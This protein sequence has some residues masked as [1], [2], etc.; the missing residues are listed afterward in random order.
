MSLFLLCKPSAGFCHLCLSLCGSELEPPQRLWQGLEVLEVEKTPPRLFTQ[1]N[2]SSTQL[3][4]GGFSH[5][6]VWS[7][8][9][10]PWTLFLKGFS[11]AKGQGT[12]K[13]QDDEKAQQQR[14]L[15]FRPPL[16][17]SIWRPP[18]A[19]D[20]NPEAHTNSPSFAIWEV[21]VLTRM[22][23]TGSFVFVFYWSVVDLQC[24]A[25]LLYIQMT[26]LYTYIHSFLYILFHHGLLQDM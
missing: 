20:P 21:G 12:G 4:T 9:V 7:L 6:R 19:A 1:G 5:H 25:T 22:L 11:S 26:Q 14:A 8:H 15:H 10:C 23:W 18:S 13:G 2:S 24:C 17:G 16:G 3:R